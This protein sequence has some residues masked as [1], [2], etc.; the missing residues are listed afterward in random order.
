MALPEKRPCPSE[1][2]VLLPRVNDWPD[3]RSGS[4]A[5]RV[6]DRPQVAVVHGPV[7]LDRHFVWA[8]VAIDPL[9]DFGGISDVH[10][11]C[12]LQLRTDAVGGACTVERQER[13]CREA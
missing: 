9:P 3:Y 8:A 11:K 5:P 7:A 13:T 4:L 6:A 10:L 2:E 1:N 12:G